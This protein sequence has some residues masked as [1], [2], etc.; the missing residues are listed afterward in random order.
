MDRGSRGIS[1][2]LNALLFNIVPTA[3]EIALVAGILTASFGPAYGAVTL[4]TVG[5]YAAFTVRV[6]ARRV[7]I[8]R[9]MNAMENQA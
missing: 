3:L 7:D 2:A 4:A 8:R 9:K 6:S 1:F 5:A